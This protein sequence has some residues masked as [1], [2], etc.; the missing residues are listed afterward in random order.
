MRECCGALEQPAGSGPPQRVGQ[1]RPCSEEQVG[2][3]GEAEPPAPCPGS[4][5]RISLS[6]PASPGAQRCRR[7]LA[8]P[9]RATRDVGLHSVN[10]VVFCSSFLTCL[11]TVSNFRGYGG[12]SLALVCQQ[13]LYLRR[14]L[15]EL[16]KGDHSQT[17]GLWLESQPGADLGD[18]DHVSL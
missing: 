4:P 16:A 5:V 18:L 6:N 13:G 7:A 8:V 12:K 10:G 11:S 9:A 1:G 2:W 3:G 15:P 14:L 17:V